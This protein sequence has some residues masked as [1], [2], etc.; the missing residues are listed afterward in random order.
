MPTDIDLQLELTV[1]DGNNEQTSASKLIINLLA[2]G[3]GPCND[4]ADNTFVPTVT[5]QKNSRS[6]DSK[7]EYQ[8]TRLFPNPAVEFLQVIFPENTNNLELQ[9]I[10]LTGSII[11]KQFINNNSKQ[12]V[13]NVSSLQQGMYLL[14]VIESGNIIQTL[15]FIK[16]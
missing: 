8:Q 9:I 5:S 2:G 3:D 16:S 14:R 11:L 1:T 6:K 10:D 13:V 12:K 15:K 4:C 7:L